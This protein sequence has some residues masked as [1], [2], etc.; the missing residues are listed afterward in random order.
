MAW[1]REQGF[2]VFTHDLD[3]GTIP[4]A[5]Q[6]AGPSVVQVRGQDVLPAAIGLLVINALRAHE[7]VLMRG[8]LLVIDSAKPRVRILPLVR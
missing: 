7:P 5:T 6:A 3:F 4:A 2:V 1:A 8:A